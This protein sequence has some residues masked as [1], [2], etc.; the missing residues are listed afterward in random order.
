MRKRDRRRR[1]TE[2][3]NGYGS[4]L[5][6]STDVCQERRGAADTPPPDRPAGSGSVSCLRC[7]D[8]T[9]LICTMR[10]YAKLQKGLKNK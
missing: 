1:G 7:S 6:G 10:F 8:L 4:V 9:N 2:E 3:A 5:L